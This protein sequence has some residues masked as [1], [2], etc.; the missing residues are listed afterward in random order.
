MIAFGITLYTPVSGFAQE[1]AGLKIAVVDINTIAEKY[2]KHKE[3]RNKLKK[4]I[5]DLQ[6]ELHKLEAKLKEYMEI[7]EL[8]D[9][10]NPKYHEYEEKI[11]EIKIKGIIKKNTEEKRLIRKQKRLVK[12]LYDDIRKGVAE[13]AKKQKYDLVMVELGDVSDEIISSN[14]KEILQKINI[15]SVIYA[16]ENL[17]ITDKVIDF[18]NAQYRKEIAEKVKHIEG[19]DGKKDTK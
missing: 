12:N 9:E 3:K 15:R 16:A 1:K 10:D 13:Y 6:E 17:D 11:E 2:E 8:Y 18:M 19:K 5:K 14:I 4:E 7:Q